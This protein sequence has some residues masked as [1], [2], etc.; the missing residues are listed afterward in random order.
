M[1][2]TFFTRAVQP[3]LRYLMGPLCILAALG[4]GWT[5]EWV[6]RADDTDLR[7]LRPLVQNAPSDRVDP[8]LE[9][10][11][12]FVSGS[13]SA[14]PI[15]DA[16]T[17][18]SCKGLRLRREAHLLQWCQTTKE[19]TR[20]QPGT[21]KY[22]HDHY[23][24]SYSQ[25]WVSSPQ[26][27]S[28]FVRKGYDNPV[29][30]SLPKE[31]NATPDTLRIGAYR[32]GPELSSSLNSASPAHAPKEKPAV[33]GRWDADKGIFYPGLKE[34]AEPQLGQMRFTYWV[35]D[36]PTEASALA[37]Q[38]G[39]SLVGYPAPSGRALALCRDGRSDLASFFQ[40][41]K[42]MN[43]FL[44]W[45]FRFSDAVAIFLGVLCLSLGRGWSWTRRLVLSSGL[46]VLAHAVPATLAFLS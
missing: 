44:V 11:L 35:T 39:D 9:G 30:A 10:K 43:S 27:S 18:L 16:D 2:G 45:F 28:K 41:E 38:K 5:S 15:Q 4:M 22:V 29:A 24:Y 8:S 19:V 40:F 21:S 17:G 33:A 26:D 20:L 37:Q 6:G 34:G 1:S 36:L 23:E 46:W 13:V 3:G 31:L 42:E 7:K 32:L 25:S 12:V 14:E